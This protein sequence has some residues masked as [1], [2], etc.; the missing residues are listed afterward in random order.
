MGKFDILKAD[1]YF[2]VFTHTGNALSVKKRPLRVLA[3]PCVR[4]FI[5][6]TIRLSLRLFTDTP[7][8]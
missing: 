6:L 2:C 8:L 3:E 4:L 7:W 1:L 5:F